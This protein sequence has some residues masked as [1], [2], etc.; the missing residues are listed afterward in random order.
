MIFVID[1]QSCLIIATEVNYL[2]HFH[3]S[4]SITKSSR[5]LDIAHRQVLLQMTFPLSRTVSHT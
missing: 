3:L 5:F 2:S 1:Q 4:L